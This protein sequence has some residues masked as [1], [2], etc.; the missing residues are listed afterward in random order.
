MRSVSDRKH[1]YT[2]R[3]TYLGLLFMLYE[4]AR[5]SHKEMPV[6]YGSTRCGVY[7]FIPN[8]PKQVTMTTATTA[9]AVITASTRKQ[10]TDHCFVIK[11]WYYLHLIKLLCPKN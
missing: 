5:V 1:L 8:R 4:L 7:L 11:V 2:S 6:L 3:L 9:V 10:S